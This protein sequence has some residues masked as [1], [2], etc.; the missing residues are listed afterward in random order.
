MKSQ[1]HRSLAGLLASVA[2][3]AASFAHEPEAG[4]K[5]GAE[6]FKPGVEYTRDQPAAEGAARPPLYA[7]L[8]DLHMEIT[9]SASEAQSYFDQGLR[10]MWGFNHAEAARSFRAGREIDPSCAMCWWGEAYAL[11]PNI[12][13]AM[14]DDAVAPAWKAV[15]TASHLAGGVSEKEAALIGALTGRYAAEPGDRSELAPAFAREMEVLARKYSNDANILVMYADALMNLQPWDYW[16][17]DGETPKG[18]GAE[19]LATLERALEVDPVHPA[20]LHLYIHAVE[21][22]SSPER[23]E[24]AADRLR[25]IAPAAGHLAH[26]PAHTYVRVGRYADS[27]DV[28]KQAIAADEAFLAAAGDAA[29]PLYRYGYYPHNVHFLMI[30][31]QMAG[32]APEAIEA[33]EKLA[34]ITDDGVSA[35]LAWVQAIKTAPY[36]AHV[37]FSDPE[38]ILAL[39]DPGDAFPFV[40]AFWHYARGTAL[41]RAGEEQ[42]AWEQVRALETMVESTDFAAL[43]DQ[44]LPARTVVEL[45][46]HVVE[47]RI[48]QAGG[49]YAAAEHHL[50]AAIELEDSIAYMEPPYWYYP[51]RQTLG[52]VLLQD[53]RPAEARAQFEAALEQTPRNA[54]AMWG[55]WQTEIETGDHH[56]RDKAADAFRDAWLGAAPPTL[57]RL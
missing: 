9:S 26:M 46:K 3:A 56:A 44:Y 43:E 38:T 23:A 7:G 4:S 8:G 39:E 12:N 30:S 16:E 42:A 19:I 33:A 32:L 54:W 41:A 11:G 29:S 14:A 2:F 27:I 31:A 53:G 36:S 37:I 35:D 55:L 13:D 20:A 49:D 6:L 52:A 24:A 51:V 18:A 1:I 48:E 47:A 50:H 34:T 21:A 10:L 45:A 25:G 40:K 22:S 17:A 15:S 5:L 57:D 28:N